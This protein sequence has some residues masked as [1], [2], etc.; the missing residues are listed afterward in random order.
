MVYVIFGAA[1]VSARTW[2]GVT[3]LPEGCRPSQEI[4]AACVGGDHRQYC[5]VV[6]AQT[7]GMVRIYA[8]TAANY[9]GTISFPVN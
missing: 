5:G 6:Q 2:Y 7:S 3:T 9:W 1:P 4:N 8:N